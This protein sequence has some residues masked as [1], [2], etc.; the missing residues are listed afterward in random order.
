MLDPRLSRLAV[1]VVSIVI[2]ILSYGSQYFLL[3]PHLSPFQFYTFNFLIASTIITY[4]RSI[5]TPAGSPP[6]SYT[7]PPAPSAADIEGGS[8]APESR[9]LIGAAATRWCKPC[10]SF[11]PPRS[12]HCRTCGTCTLRMDHHC[13]WTANCVGFANLPHFLRFLVYS[14]SATGYLFQLLLRR[15][16]AL[17]EARELPEHLGPHTLGQMFFLA[18]LSLVSFPLWVALLVLLLRTLA[19]VGE[20]YTTIETWEAERHDAAVRRRHARRVVFPYDIGLW[21]NA[22][23]A[24]GYTHNPLNM[25]NPLSHTPVIGAKHPI[26]SGP[27]TIRAG[28]DWEVNGFEDA[29]T[30]W[31][32]AA[33]EPG[34]EDGVDL[35]T[36]VRGATPW[37]VEGVGDVGAFRR[38][39]REDARRRGLAYG[40]EDDEEE[41]DE[42]EEAAY[43]EVRA[44][45]AQRAWTN[46]EGERLA[47]YGVDEDAEGD[48]EDVPLAVLRMRLEGRKK[49]A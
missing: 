32:P 13:P 17:Y 43:R 45:R 5:R 49:T 37:T 12:H 6:P 27:G 48:D 44:Q 40:A 25:L 15:W 2:F 26:T 20:G 35:D 8:G 38:R 30:V 7:P 29:D 34:V 24:M 36:G 33:C 39:Q 19:T 9:T 11:K 47:D 28:L 1:T 42:E 16:Y 14:T 31:P 18:A 41:V 23:C 3:S 22:V 21:E 10:S 46:A 4:Y